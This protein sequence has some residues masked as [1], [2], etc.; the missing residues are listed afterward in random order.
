[1]K[2][3]VATIVLTIM[4][5]STTTGYYANASQTS[6]QQ[7]DCQALLASLYKVL[8]YIASNN[9]I[10]YTILEI[11]SNASLPPQ[12]EGLHRNLVTDLA[13]YISIYYNF[14][15][16]LSAADPVAIARVEDLGNRLQADLGAYVSTL[17]AC[18][19]DKSV[20]DTLASKIRIAGSNLAG[21]LERIAEEIAASSPETKIVEFT[22][23]NK[24]IYPGEN[25][26]IR[27]YASKPGMYRGLITVLA[28]P[29]LVPIATISFNLTGLEQRLDLNMPPAYEL[30]YLGRGVHSLLVVLKTLEPVNSTIYGFI[31]L[32]LEE[33]ILQASSPKFLKPGDSIVL[34]LTVREQCN[35]SILLDSLEVYTGSLINGSNLIVL[36]IPPNTTPGL[37]NIIVRTS[38]GERFIGATISLPAIVENPVL[39]VSIRAPQVFI[40]FSNMIPVVVENSSLVSSVR[41]VE[42]SAT[43]VVDLNRSQVIYLKGGI[44]LFDR[45]RA[46][47]VFEPINDSRY[48]PAVLRVEVLYV[49]PLTVTILGL[50]AV[51]IIPVISGYERE[52][53]LMLKKPLIPALK[54]R[55]PGRTGPAA[56]VS[57]L[58]K[59]LP[60]AGLYYRLLE[61]L[62]VREPSPYETLRE[63]L[64]TISLP[65][66]VK[67]LLFKLLTLVE[68]E[69]Y[70]RHKPSREEAE[71]LAREVRSIEV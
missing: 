18:S 3:L 50:V 2:T 47:L 30:Y 55:V 15:Q 12:I 19:V 65:A 6:L 20:A 67:T 48:Q 24:T 61:E 70:S 69:L 35:A 68:R 43:I 31:N 42:G 40:S 28:L 58:S 27:V 16:Y 7:V 38:P 52:F 26:S 21:Y 10:A 39:P 41:V 33:N 36:Q 25:L 22:V 13:E 54:S 63:H 46:T 60:V 44:G 32:V 62:G 66:I 1:M 5:I 8:T 34:N 23:D 29:G 59:H 11:Y 53:Y 51:G 4:I 64:N 37:H 71:E 56:I 17:V 57:V 9:T 14:T 45:V 49:N